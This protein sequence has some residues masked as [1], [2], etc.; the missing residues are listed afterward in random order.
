M[1]TAHSSYRPRDPTASVVYPVLSEHWETWVARHEEA[2]QAIPAYVRRE[3]DSFLRCGDPTN[4]FLRL[5]CGQCRATRVLPFSCK[6]RSLCS[7]CAARTMA[8]TAA[9]LVDRVIAPDVPVRQ[10]VLTLPFAIRRWVAF[11]ERLLSELH[12]IA[13]R[14]ISDW[15]RASAAARTRAKTADKRLAEP[16]AVTFVQRFGDALRLAPHF[17]IM[18]SDGVFAR[19]R[20]RKCKAGRVY[21]RTTPAPTRRDVQGIV[22]RIARE[23][24][25][26]L[27]RSRRDTNEEASLID[28]CAAIAVRPVRPVGPHCVRDGEPTRRRILPDQCAERDGWNLHAGTRVAAHRPLALERLLRYAARPVIAEDRLEL[29]SDG[30]IKITLKRA[31][32]DGRA[33]VVLSPE[34]FLTRLVALIPLPHSNLTRYSGAWS[35]RSRWRDDAIPGRSRDRAVSERNRNKPELRPRRLAWADLLKRVFGLDAFQCH[36]CPARMMVVSVIEQPTV[37]EAIL[38][39]IQLSAPG[40]RRAPARDPPESDSGAFDDAPCNDD[41]LDPAWGE[42]A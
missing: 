9:H 38:A 17:H 5:Y 23:G 21:F 35:A 20:S 30:R 26:A 8:D 31:W 12:R 7:S 18:V 1:A 11:D 28:G 29:L 4:G 42:P 39:A 41:P 22:D 2:G 27:T 37:I 16:G 3:V 13:V 25:A 19:R 6:T 32:S 14:A 15:L 36:C 40:R 34:A 10:W 33:F 24:T